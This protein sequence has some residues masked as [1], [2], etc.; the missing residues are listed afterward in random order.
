MSRRAMQ[1]QRPN[2]EN[3]VPRTPNPD[4]SPLLETRIIRQDAFRA[5]VGLC[6]MCAK[7]E[8]EM[9]QDGYRLLVEAL[10]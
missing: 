2:P 10:K 1:F 9:C 4:E 3:E 6:P 8:R 5:H 7:D